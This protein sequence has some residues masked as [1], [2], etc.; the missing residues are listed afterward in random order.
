MSDTT[1][2]QSDE[3][4]DH[5]HAMWSA[6][7][8][9]WAANADFIDDRGVD[10]TDAMLFITAPRPGERV[11]ELGCGPGGPGFAAAPL[12]APT[13]AVVVSD[14]SAEMTAI[15]ADR[16][17]ERGLESVSCRVLDLEQIDEPDSSFDV[18]LCREALML[19]AD[20]A[21]AAAEIRRVLA[22]GGRVA[23]SV[24]GS[25]ED[26][27]W[28]GV[29]FDVVSDQLGMPVPP[30]GLPHPFS[31]HDS[32]R[33]AALLGDAGLSGITVT[34]MPTPYRAASVDEWWERTKALAGPL[35]AMLAALPDSEARALRDRAAVAIAPYSGPP[36][37]VIPG[38]CL[39]ATASV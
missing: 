24:W 13:G 11:L 17:R 5:L 32:G 25:R 35:G 8:P 20:P 28:L 2:R 16:V 4:R 26:N 39:L 38:A 9:G 19:V 30:P 27:P 22:P 37:L 29:V 14:V 7:A 1:I 34:E 36:G 33:L 3:L 15:A 21:R 6:V 10:V 23:L 12:V 31:L 18:V